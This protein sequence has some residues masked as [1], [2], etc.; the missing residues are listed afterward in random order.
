MGMHTAITIT[1]TPEQRRAIQQWQSS[2]TVP[3]GEAKRGRLLLLLADGVTVT[4][5]AR[6]AGIGRRKVYVWV[7]R[8]QALGLAGLHNRRRRAAT[9]LRARGGQ[10]SPLAC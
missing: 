6:R 2:R 10:D 9:C 5:A 7:R 3:Y 8:F 4:E 1:L